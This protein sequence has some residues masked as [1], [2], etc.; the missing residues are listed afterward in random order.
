MLDGL[1]SQTN[2]VAPMPH[3][4]EVSRETSKR[5]SSNALSPENSS[6]AGGADRLSEKTGA[7]TDE[8]S[9]ENLLKEKERSTDDQD[10]S[11]ALQDQLSMVSEFAKKLHNELE[12]STDDDSGRTIVKVINKETEE[13]IRQ[14][15]SDE[16]LRMS[17]SMDEVKGALFSSQA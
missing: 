12:F 14:I 1:S 10:T 8:I 17:N 15:P 7:L 9:N 16:F 4:I 3:S 13:I 11:L 5:P 2:T 6:S